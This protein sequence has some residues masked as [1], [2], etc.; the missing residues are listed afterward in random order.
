MKAAIYKD[1]PIGC[2][3]DV[4]AE[5]EKYTGGI[6]SQHVSDIEINHEVSVL[7]WGSENGEDYW[8]VRNSWGTYWGEWGF[9]RIKMFSDN[10]GIESDCDWGIP[11]VGD[12]SELP[13]SYAVYDQ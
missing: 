2:G 4:T 8:I 3:M 6:Y 12:D 13:E 5:F 1:G 10:L 11:I 7:G 9:F